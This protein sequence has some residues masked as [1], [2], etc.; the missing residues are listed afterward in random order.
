M[1]TLQAPVA[2]LNIQPITAWTAL[3]MVCSIVLLA[4]VVV[5]IWRRYIPEPP[6]P[7]FDGHMK[8]I[9]RRVS[10]K[11]QISSRGSVGFF[12]A[13]IVITYL[14]FYFLTMLMRGLH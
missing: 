7:N 3:G 1:L 8:G 14:L 12:F 4:L 2:S 11:V 9:G 10:G 6:N 13:L 5:L